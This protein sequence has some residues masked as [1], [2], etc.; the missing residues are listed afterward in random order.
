MKMLSVQII[1]KIPLSNITI[2]PPHSFTAH[3]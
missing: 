3:P 1:N 2:K